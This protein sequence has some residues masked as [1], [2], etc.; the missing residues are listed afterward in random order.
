MFCPLSRR[1]LTK[2]PLTQSLHHRLSA[3]LTALQQ[4]RWAA[5][6]KVDGFFVAI[7]KKKKARIVA[8]DQESWHFVVWV[9]LFF[10]IDLYSVCVK[11]SVWRGS[12]PTESKHAP[13]AI[14]DVSLRPQVL[15]MF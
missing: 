5:D 7:K 8:V 13:A 1:V 11:V 10:F 15:R 3:F 2:F 12:S 9:I 6:L 4:L 14:S